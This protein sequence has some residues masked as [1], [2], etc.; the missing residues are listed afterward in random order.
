M[1]ITLENVNDITVIH[2]SGKLDTVTAPDLEAVVIEL[3]EKHQFKLIFDLT[4]MTYISSSGLRVLLIAQKKLAP[5]NREAILNGLSES[6][7]SIFEISGFTQLFCFT[8]TL[9][10]A[11]NSIK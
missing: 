11:L 3:I 6:L 7:H 9:D 8:D 1:Q 4:K 10:S 2:I 5:H